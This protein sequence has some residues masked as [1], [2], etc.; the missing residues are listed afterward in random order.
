MIH[1][2]KWLF[3]LILVSVEVY[4][5]GIASLV[6]THSKTGNR[7]YSKEVQF[8]FLTDCSIHTDRNVCSCALDKIQNE[9]SEKQFLEIDQALKL[10]KKNSKFTVFL[11]KVVSQC[12]EL[13]EVKKNATQMPREEAEKNADIFFQNLNKKSYVSGCVEDRKVSYGRTLAKQVCTCVYE[14]LVSDTGRLIQTFMRDGKIDES[15]NW[16]QDYL[17]ECLPSEFEPDFEVAFVDSLNRLGAP[18]SVAECMVDR[19]KKENSFPAFIKA[20]SDGNVFFLGVLQ[21][22]LLSCAEKVEEVNR[23][24]YKRPV[25]VLTPLLDEVEL[26]EGSPLS[27]NEVAMVL[28]NRISELK[29]IY[30]HYLRK[31]GDF[32]GA[33]KLKMVIEASGNVSQVSVVYSSTGHENFNDAVRTAAKAWI[34]PKVKTGKTGVKVPFYFEK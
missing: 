17:F 27:V 21:K 30:E 31:E 34:F 7:D 3:V 19:I 29:L 15:E 6:A 18:K 9:Y 2:L 26:S 1:P 5:D 8:S 10:G 22:F 4:A 32:Q 25:K 33:V 12:D 23:Y 14:N 16:G 13:A 24:G 28:R 11:K 20:S